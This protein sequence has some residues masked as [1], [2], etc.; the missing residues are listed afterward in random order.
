VPGVEHIRI[1]STSVEVP[2]FDAAAAPLEPVSSLRGSVSGFEFGG[3]S[4]RA[5]DLADAALLGG[6]VHAVRAEQAAMTRVDVRSV[7]FTGCELGSLRWT[8]GKVSRARFDDCKLLGAR[9]E[10]VSLEHVVFTGCKLDYALF[11]KVR[12]TGPVLFAGCSLR[13]A[14]F[15]GCSLPG[16][17][18]DDCDLSLAAFGPGSYRG[19]D[20]RGNDLS[21]VL[22]AHQLKRVVL[23]RAQVLQL[24]SALAV[25]LEVDFGDDLG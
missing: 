22:G 1:R 20:L 18:L 11:D 7:E 4:V 2:V 21:S 23:D 17:L 5:L 8:G 14:E 16:S 19:C 3:T 10:G 12:A 13:E 6:R 25:Q 9:F 15:N 24:A